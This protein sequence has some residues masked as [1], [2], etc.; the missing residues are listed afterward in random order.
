MYPLLA[1]RSL[2]RFFKVAS[3]DVNPNLPRLLINAC[4]CRTISSF[5]I[6]LEKSER[7]PTMMKLEGRNIQ[8]PVRADR[9]TDAIR[10]VG[11]LLVDSGYWL[12]DIR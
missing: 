11:K 7:R 5:S 1:G 9:K 12:L 6:H 4:D 10:K 3:A 8:L 2:Q